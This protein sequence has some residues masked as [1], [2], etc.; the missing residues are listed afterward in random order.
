VL[1]KASALAQTPAPMEASW[2]ARDFKFH[3]GEVASELRLNYTTLGDP[4]GEPILILHGTTGS[5]SSL[6]S[7]GF[8]GE[9]FGPGQPLDAAK[10]F[11]ILPDAI[12]HG[13]SA[14]PSD[15]L[16]AKFPKYNYDDMVVAQY[17]LV[18]EGLGVKH[19]RLVLGNSMGGMHTWMWG[20]QYPDFMDALVP[21]AAQPTEMSSRNWMLRRLIIDTI[22]NDADWNEGNYTSQPR[23]LKAAAVFYG[24][25][26]S[27][28]TLALQREAPTRALADKL[29]DGRLA[30]PFKADANDFLYQWDASRDYNASPGLERI[31]AALL[32][33]NSA[34]DERNPPE[35]GLMEREL[36]RVPNASLY[37]IPASEETRGHGTTGMA[38]FWKSQVQ[39][40]LASVSR[41]AM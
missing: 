13:K 9:L 28:G 23:A 31:K 20:T 39:E 14:K 19:L 15:G 7:P 5:G 33:I 38:K 8:G 6:L 37:L 25:A 16:R 35:T 21:M 4:T 1:L 27:G 2:T 26:T 32:A 24:I 3:S 18:T 17:R 30:A 36:K 11:I 10:Y 29:L 12:G 22:R 40:F 41:R 34:D